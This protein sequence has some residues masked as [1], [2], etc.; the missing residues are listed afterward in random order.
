MY[1]LKDEISPL[2]TGVVNVTTFSLIDTESTEF[3]KMRELWAR[4]GSG[5]DFA[6]T[7]AKVSIIGVTI[8]F[9]VR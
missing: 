2:T 9:I 4:H 6:H 3:A 5:K 1:P 8:V 7:M